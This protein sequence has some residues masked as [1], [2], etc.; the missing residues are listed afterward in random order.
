MCNYSFA[1]CFDVCKV[2]VFLLTLSSDKCWFETD[3]FRFPE[4][5]YF[6]RWQFLSKECEIL[7]KWKTQV[8]YSLCN[9]PAC[10]KG[11]F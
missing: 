1:Y 9:I 2:T 6:P 5:D 11:P 8:G 4:M 7:E 3:L 10:I